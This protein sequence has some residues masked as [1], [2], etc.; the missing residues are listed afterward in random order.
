MEKRGI[1]MPTALLEEEVTF[2]TKEMR[3]IIMLRNAFDKKI[4]AARESKAIPE[5]W[6]SLDPA[7]SNLGHPELYIWNELPSS[8]V[9]NALVL[10]YEQSGWHVTKAEIPGIDLYKKGVS[11]LLRPKSFLDS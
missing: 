8:K 11:L 6:K 3:K 7:A 4:S 1:H 9:V 10:Y 5:C 2:S